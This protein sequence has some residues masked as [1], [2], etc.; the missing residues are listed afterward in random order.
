MFLIFIMLYDISQSTYN[1]KSVLLFTFIQ[2]PLTLQLISSNQKSDIFFEFVSS[3]SIMDLQQYVSFCYT[4]LIWHFCK[5]KMIVLLSLVMMSPYKDLQLLIIFLTLYLVQYIY[6]L[7]LE[8]WFLFLRY[9]S[10]S[11]LNF[12]SFAVLLL[13]RVYCCCI[14]VYIFLFC[15]SLN[16]LLQI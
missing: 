14:I 9:W 1:W 10:L 16:Y 3:W 12:N 8:Y 6:M 15:L 11:S 7:I 13:A 4:T 5:F 2:F